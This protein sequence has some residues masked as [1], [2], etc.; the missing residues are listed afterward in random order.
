MENKSFVIIEETVTFSFTNKN[1]KTDFARIEINGNNF[2]MYRD[3]RVLLHCSASSRDK[4][5]RMCQV[6]LFKNF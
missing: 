5:I 4:G 1:G 2:I 6:F 3:S